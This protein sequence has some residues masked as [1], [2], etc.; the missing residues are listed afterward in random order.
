[1]RKLFLSIFLSVI[2]NAGIVCADCPPGTNWTLAW[3]ADKDSTTYTLTAPCKVYIGIPFT[4]TASVS[5]PDCLN[6]WVATFWSIRDNGNVIAGSEGF[7]K[8]FTDATGQWQTVIDQTYYGTPVDHTI[9]FQVTDNGRCSGFHNSSNFLF[10]SITVDPYP[11]SD[12]TPPSANAGPD[13]MISSQ[14]QSSTVIYGTATDEDGDV[15][16]YRWLEGTTELQPYQPVDSSGNALLSLGTLLPLSIGAHI[17][18]LDVSDG[19]DISTDEV[20]VSVENSPPTVAPSGGGTYQIWSDISL[21]G[22]LSDYDG[23]TIIYKWIEGSTLLFSGTVNTTFGGAPVTIP[24]Y[25]IAG[26]LPLGTHTLTLEV[27]DGIHTVSSSITVTVVDTVAPSLTP[28]ANTTILWP[29]NHK[30]VDVTI[31]SNATDNSNGAVSLTVM[32]NC[33]EPPDYDNDGNIIPDYSIVQIDQAS[34]VIYLQL[35]ASK[36]GSKGE[37]IYTVTITATDESG[38]SSSADVQIKVPHDM[39]KK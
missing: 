1:M 10:S 14:D 20:R 36:A 4:I 23:E 29:P 8:L 5:D 32:V 3:Q 37:R 26:G 18:T 11:P 34:G 39:K 13:I 17:L 28:V 12:N 38:N 35:R 30:M 25:V 16:T 9:G 31:N 7:N 33:N 6:T 27:G 15:L 2:I 22:S 21:S 24:E 19:K